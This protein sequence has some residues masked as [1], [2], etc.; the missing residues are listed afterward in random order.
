MSLIFVLNTFRA[1]TDSDTVVLVADAYTM[2]NPNHVDSVS[3]KNAGSANGTNSGD[4]S[5]HSDNR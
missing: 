4:G 1:Q 5:Y 2:V 3:E